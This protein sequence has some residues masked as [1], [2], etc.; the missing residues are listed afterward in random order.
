MNYPTFES[1]YRERDGVASPAAPLGA[2]P[3]MNMSPQQMQEM[4]EQPPVVESPWAQLLLPRDYE[5][6]VSF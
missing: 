5:E 3:Q 4:P 1:L 2:G 6:P